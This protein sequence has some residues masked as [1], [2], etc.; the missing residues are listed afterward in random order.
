MCDRISLQ[1]KLTLSLI[2]GVEE[3]IR[4]NKGLKV[5]KD[6]PVLYQDLSKTTTQEVTRA[7][8]NKHETNKILMLAAVVGLFVVI[9]FLI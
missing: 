1:K 2:A 4:L 3:K 5:P 9:D 7:Y 8:I 6:V